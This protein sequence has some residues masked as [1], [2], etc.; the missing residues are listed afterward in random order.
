MSFAYLSV[1][2]QGVP[3]GDG[4]HVGLVAA[5]DLIRRT[6]LFEWEPTP[7]D[8]P[9]G[10][11][12]AR[13]SLEG[14]RVVFGNVPAPKRSAILRHYPPIGLQQTLLDWL[15]GAGPED[16]K[17]V[18]AWIL[19]AYRSGL[20]PADVAPYPTI[21]LFRGFL[22]DHAENGLNPYREWFTE[23]EAT[24]RAFRSGL[25]AARGGVALTDVERTRAGVLLDILAF[26]G[27]RPPVGDLT[28]FPYYRLSQVDPNGARPDLE[29]WDRRYAAW[30][31]RRPWA[32]PWA[33]ERRCKD[34]RFDADTIPRGWDAGV[35]DHE[36]RRE[37]RRRSRLDRT[38][39][40]F[41]R[42]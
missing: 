13:P 3:A 4:R 22:R 9:I 23:M 5:G 31:S 29:G 35:V 30:L 2:L 10:P 16:D 14:L 20:P 18:L 7:P 40:R 42:P 21:N 41:R 27:T 39:W 19:E 17:D 28:P 38:R 11:A 15:A 12:L 36:Q 32:A 34:W 25:E 24:W 6:P 8:G 37:E 33:R 26:P 1:G